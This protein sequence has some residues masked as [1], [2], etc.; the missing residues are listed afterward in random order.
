MYK[1]TKYPTSSLSVDQSYVGETIEEKVNRIVNNNE[2]I[3]DGAP[4]VYTN[5]KDGVQPDYDI[6][7]DRFEI[8]TEASDIVTKS[9]LAK[10]EERAKVLKMDDKNTKSDDKNTSKN[11]GG[12]PIQGTDP[13][14]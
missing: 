13:G 14:K 11:A 1:Q 12:E 10:R 7:T 8:A 9:H 5:R 2:P 6:R 4:L 3:T